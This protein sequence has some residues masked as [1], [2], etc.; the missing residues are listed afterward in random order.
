MLTNFAVSPETVETVKPRAEVKSGCCCLPLFEGGVCGHYDIIRHCLW[1]QLNRHRKSKSTAGS[2]C[3]QQQQQLQVASCQL[4]LPSVDSCR[5][6][7]A[8]C[9]CRRL[10]LKFKGYLHFVADAIAAA[11]LATEPTTETPTTATPTAAVSNSS[12]SID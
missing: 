6:C 2:N 12:K 9:H 5:T 11:S 10:L 4:L 3:Q 1:R 8:R 7:V